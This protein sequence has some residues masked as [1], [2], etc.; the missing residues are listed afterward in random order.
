[1]PTFWNT[2]EVYDPRT[3]EPYTKDGAWDRVVQELGNGCVL[4]AVA[5]DKPPGKT[6]YTFKFEDAKGQPIYVKL[7]MLSGEVR[8][9]SF[10]I[11]RGKR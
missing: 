6:G 3:G 8:G 11:D 9:R 2:G 10:H 7:Q 4:S 1:M 5:L